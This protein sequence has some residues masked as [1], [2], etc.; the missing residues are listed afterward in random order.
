[1]YNNLEFVNNLGWWSSVLQIPLGDTDMCTRAF[2]ASSFIWREVVGTN[3]LYG[4]NPVVHSSL[5]V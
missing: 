3:D 2:G 1:M 5:K 4:M